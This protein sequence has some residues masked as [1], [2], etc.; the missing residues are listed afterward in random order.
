VGL[1]AAAFRQ[2]IRLQRTNAAL[3]DETRGLV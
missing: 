1:I 3:E 2:G